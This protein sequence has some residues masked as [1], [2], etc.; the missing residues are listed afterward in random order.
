MSGSGGPAKADQRRE[1]GRAAGRQQTQLLKQ[2]AGHQPGF[3]FFRQCCPHLAQSGHQG[4]DV[5]LKATFA[6]GNDRGTPVVIDRSKQYDV[7][8][9]IN[10]RTYRIMVS[11]PP[12]VG[13]AVAYPV[14]YLL[15]GNL[16]FATAT[17]ALARQAFNKLVAPAIVVAIGYPTDDEA[18]WARRRYLDLTPSTPSGPD[19]AITAPT[20]DNETFLR[21]IEEEVKP[22]VAAR[23]KV[24]STK[25]IIYGQSLGG[26]TA[27]RSLFRNPTAFSTYIL[28]SP[29]IWW[30]HKTVLADEE[31]FSK[32]ARAGELRLRI[33]VT[34]A[35]DEQYRGDDPKALAKD[36]RMVDEASE[37]AA[38][39][40]ILDPSRVVVARTIFEGEVHLLVPPASL[41]RAL[42]FALPIPPAQP[43]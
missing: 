40:A 38:R 9:R 25:Q 18:E 23:Y 29:S 17:S 19:T 13:S 14:L 8:S 32:R 37:L 1:P 36:V 31:A 15:D 16:Y 21:F 4:R 27:L 11:T 5:A 2:K 34:S 24:D 3:F 28:S 6:E 7:K 12:G 41:S 42:R 43:H 33:L 20:G 39:L 30:D 35:G 22:F 26:L 10:G